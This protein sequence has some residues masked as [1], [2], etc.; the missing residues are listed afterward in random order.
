M[1][2]VNEYFEGKVKSL[3]F[4]SEGS[5]FTAGVILA[6]EYT[7]DTGQEEHFTITVGDWKSSFWKEMENDEGRRDC[8]DSSQF[9]IQFEGGSASFLC[10]QICLGRQ[11]Y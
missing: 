10:L 5:R 8:S 2:K 11:V 3:G 9:K 4:E 7:F 1:I 6:G